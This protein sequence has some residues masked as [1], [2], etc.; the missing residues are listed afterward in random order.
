MSSVMTFEDS[1]KA[2]IKSIVADLIPEDRWEAIVRS[3]VS[4]FEKDDLPKLIKASLTV[5]YQKIIAAEF[6]KPEWQQNWNDPTNPVSD[7]VKKM[8]I[9][10]APLILASML[11]NSAQS[12]VDTL[13]YS[14]QN[15]R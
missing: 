5:E 14:I 8:L 15:M 12:M 7:A 10:A 11:S 1:V 9:D 3:T 6:A 4:S 2:R 13:R